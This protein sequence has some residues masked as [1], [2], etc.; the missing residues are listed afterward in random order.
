MIRILIN[1]QEPV[2]LPI[3]TDELKER[4]SFSPD[5]FGFT[6]EIMGS[7]TF[8]GDDFTFFW[9]LFRTGVCT[10][11]VVDIQEREGDNGDWI[12]IWFGLIY[13]KDIEFNADKRTAKAEIIDNSFVAKIINYLDTPI[14]LFTERTRGGE[15]ISITPQSILVV[16]H[17]N[18]TQAGIVAYTLVDLLDYFTRFITDNNVTVQSTYLSAAPFDDY[19]FV[20]GTDLRQ[21]G[22]VNTLLIKFGD[23]LRDVCR[24]FNTR[25][26]IETN[27]NGNVLRIENVEYFE[28]SPLIEVEGFREFNVTTN[29]ELDYTSFAF[30]SHQA[31]I[32]GFD[33]TDTWVL[34][35]LIPPFSGYAE[36]IISPDG[37]CQTKAEYSLKTRTICYDSN[38]IS[39]VRNNTTEAEFD[40]VLFIVTDAGAAWYNIESRPI[41]NF[42]L[43]C[44]NQ[45][46]RWLKSYCFDYPTQIAACDTFRETENE[47]VIGVANILFLKNVLSGCYSYQS[48]SV[49]EPTATVSIELNLTFFADPLENPPGVTTGTMRMGFRDVSNPFN[50]F[51]APFTGWTNIGTISGTNPPLVE[52][53]EKNFNINETF[54]Y[55]CLIHNITLEAFYDL[56]TVMLG[57]PGNIERLELINGSYI[58]IRNN[59]YQAFDGSQCRFQR[60]KVASE[61]FLPFTKA[62]EIRD[63]RFGNILLPNNF[64]NFTGNVATLERNLVNNKAQLTINAQNV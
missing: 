29:E 40:D 10:E 61:G 56:F 24:L 35:S 26:V 39:K 60:F 63:S 52:L 50:I 33:S 25:W 44:A 3:G 18:V 23:L 20:R 13:I 16:D 30:G 12:G 55:Q 43:L 51:I 5:L 9:D 21:L 59:S 49:L 42:E 54:T 7:L 22:G 8:Y 27:Q 11:A 64:A 38:T 31:T 48:I 47:F 4:F 58:K 32:T 14:S 45:L 34:R 2:N 41:N 19:Y 37:G 1:G 28:Q 17:N 36:S 62:K 46:K 53:V 57:G 15:P 6:R